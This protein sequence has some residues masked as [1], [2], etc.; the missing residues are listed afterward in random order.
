MVKRNSRS[1]SGRRRAYA[2]RRAK[3]VAFC[4]QHSAY[5]AAQSM[6]KSVP[7]AV[8]VVKVRCAGEVQTEQILKRFEDG[9]NRVLVLG[10]PLDNCKYLRGNRRA[11]KR[12]AV[13]GRALKD[14]G[15]DESS[16]RVEL[17]SSVDAHKLKDILEEVQKP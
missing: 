10:C 7:R 14:A 11:L 9:A 12:A 4:C 2:R 8:E 15:L 5:K 16:V 3:I 1:D 13:A 17:I 6:G